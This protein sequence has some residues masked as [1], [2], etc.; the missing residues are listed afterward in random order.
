MKLQIK[1]SVR[2]IQVLVPSL[3]DARFTAHRYILQALGRPWRPD[4]GVMRYF[5]IK[6]P[7]IVDVGANRGFSI[8][9][10]LM[11]KPMAHI[12]GFEPMNFFAEA[13]KQRY[14]NNPNVTIHSCALGVESSNMRIYVPVYRGYLLDPLASLNYSEAANW[15][16][17]ERFYFFNPNKLKIEEETVSVVP[18]DDFSL[19]PDIIKIYAQGYEPE[20]I[21][22]GE[23]TL[24]QYEPAIMVPARIPRIDSCLRGFGYTRY[25]FHKSKLYSE[26]E[27]HTSSWYLKKKHL[28]L[29]RCQIE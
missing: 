18:L 20:V 5:E 21:R 7:V 14:I 28:S 12:V 29:F 27:G 15:V 17:S 25:A 8:F 3:R 19:K 22:G 2:T 16:N 11:I 10:F 24:N 9:S 13:L 6:D 26:G 23:L 4:V 1:K